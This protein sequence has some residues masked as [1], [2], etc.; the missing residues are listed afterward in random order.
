[1]VYDNNSIV[2][3][4]TDLASEGYT[5]K[6]SLQPGEEG[7]GYVVTVVH[8]KKTV[9]TGED[10]DLSWAMEFAYSDTPER[11]QILGDGRKE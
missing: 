1:M 9:A 8:G 2:E 7:L 4:I 6:I 11:E 5:V 3:M 10:P